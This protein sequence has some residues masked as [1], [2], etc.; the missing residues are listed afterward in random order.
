M[1]KPSVLKVRKI[2]DV[3]EKVAELRKTDLRVDWADVKTVDG[4][5]RVALW[6]SELIGK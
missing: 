6:S 4:R 3:I 2:P 5:R 1:K